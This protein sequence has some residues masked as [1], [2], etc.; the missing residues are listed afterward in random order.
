MKSFWNFLN[1]NKLYGAVNLVGLTVSM[2]FVLL[3]AVYV[4][5]QLSTDSFQ[6]NAD[7]VYLIANENNVS[8]AYWLDKHLKNNFPEIEK[9]CC[10]AM[11]SEAARY[12]IGDESVYG[13]TMAVDSTFFDLFSYDLVA[14]NKADWSISWDRCMVSQ[15]FALAHFG[16]KDPLGRILTM[17]NVDGPEDAQLTICGVYEDFG[18][19][20]LEAP[21]VLVRGE[22]MPKT[23]PA[24]DEH[25]PQ[26]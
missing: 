19:S 6:E 26:I 3:L 10:V 5:R 4:Q 8:M 11:M 20:I 18:N 13:S 24:H 14:G 21:D 7:R 25:T 15:A 2:A 1:K 16:E 12:T 17:K 23:N 9:G 22:L